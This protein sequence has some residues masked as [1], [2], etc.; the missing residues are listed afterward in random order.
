MDGPAARGAGQPGGGDFHP[1]LFPFFQPR[2]GSWPT[3]ADKAAG[4]PPGEAPLEAAIMALAAVGF[5]LHSL[6]V[7][8]AALFLLGCHSTRCSGRSNTP[9]CPSICTRTNW[10]G[11]A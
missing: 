2:P 5:G 7:L 11:N 3:N 10:W 4:C 6:A 8:L 1:A 9:S